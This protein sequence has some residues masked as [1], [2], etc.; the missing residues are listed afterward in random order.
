[1]PA[2]AEATRHPLRVLL[3]AHSFN[4]LTQRLFAELRRRGHAVSLELDISDAVTQEAVALFRPDVVIAPFLKRRIPDAVWQN[5]LCLV[6]HPGVPGDRGPSALDRALLRGEA[7]WGV[8]VLQATGEF[9]AGP[10]WASAGFA[11]RAATKASIYRNEVSRC[12]V[13]AVLECLRRLERGEGVPAMDAH[14]VSGRDWPPLRQAERALHWG[15]DRT[16][17]ILL[18]IRAADGSPGLADSLF[19]QPCHLFDGHAA[20]PETLAAAPPGLPGEVVARRANALLRRT[21][22]GGV[23]IGHVRRAAAAGTDAALKLPATD[24]FGT[25]AQALPELG[26]PLERDAAEWDEL[27]YRELGNAGA[28]VG[29]LEFDFYNG[30]MSTRQ[31]GR[32]ARAIRELRGRPVRVLVLAGG[33]DFF[34]NG[35]HLNTIEAEGQAPGGSAADASLRNIEAIDDVALEILTLTDRLTVSAL[36]GNAGAGGVFLALAADEVWA[37]PGVV[38]NAHYKNMGNLYG[39]EYWTY[40]LPRRLGLQRANEVTQARLPQLTAEAM[41]E[42]L[43]DASFGDDPNHF[44]E[45]ALARALAL[46]EDKGYSG[47]VSG[48]QARRDA[49]EATKPLAAYREEELTRMRR[50]FYGFDPSYHVARYHFVHKLAQAWTPRHL[51]LHR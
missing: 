19:G 14:G 13:A 26:V 47:R 31:C 33:A 49:D 29:V 28:L 35:V 4:S 48:K 50:N 18:A 44:F 37:H 27:R 25:K 40:V 11:M 23:W 38:L 21:V 1:M 41:H 43:V 8:T 30:A 15:R 12:A 42:G 9:D 16:A 34:S 5:H 10:V 17:A 7:Y 20:T 45:L 32:L 39:S 2:V 46:A 24:A 36:R 6:V 3:L 51:A 22:D